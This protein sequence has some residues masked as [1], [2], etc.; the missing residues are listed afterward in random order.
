MIFTVFGILIIKI[1]KKGGLYIMVIG[2]LDTGM[3]QLGPQGQ[4]GPWTTRPGGQLGP[5]PTEGRVGHHV[6]GP[7]GTTRPGTTRPASNRRS[8]LARIW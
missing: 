4:L 3:G 8:N 6:S 1:A 5:H 2:S 7:A